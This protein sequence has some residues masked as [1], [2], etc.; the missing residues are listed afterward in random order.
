MTMSPLSRWDASFF[1]LS[2][3]RVGWQVDATAKEYLAAGDPVISV[4]AKKKEQV[5]QYATAGR[6]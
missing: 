1:N 3:R 5:G 2:F 4:D 6:C